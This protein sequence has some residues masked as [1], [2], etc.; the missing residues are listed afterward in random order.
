MANKELFKDFWMSCNVICDSGI[1]HKFCI[2]R[3]STDHV[4]WEF[5]VS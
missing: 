3:Y 1:C 2:H 5:G 4:I